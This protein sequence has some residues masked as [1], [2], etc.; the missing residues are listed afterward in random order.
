MPT[1]LRVAGFRV[2][3]F[4]P[5]REHQPPHVHVRHATGEVVIEL[6]T[7]GRPQIIRDA[8]GMRNPDVA[9][10]FWIVEA[11]TDHLLSRWR[12]YHG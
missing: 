6:A 10:A 7:S 9:T 4:L 12:D 1:V 11:H 3:I 2:V 5:P 8:V